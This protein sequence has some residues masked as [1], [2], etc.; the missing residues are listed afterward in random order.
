MRKRKKETIDEI[1]RR[2][3]KVR[4]PLPAAYQKIY[5]Q[6]YT[7]NRNAVTKASKATAFMERW[8]HK[9]VAKTLRYVEKG[10]TLEI[11]AGTLNQ[12]NF[13]T[14]T[15]EYDIVE[16]YSILFESSPY[17]KFVD[18]V[19][20]DISL[21]PLEKKYDRIISILSFEHILNLPNVIK[22]CG[23]LLKD[24]GFMSVSIP[25]E[26]RF[27]W[28]F[29]YRNTSGREFQRRFGLDYSVIMHY[30][31]VNTADE[32]EALIK[33]YF[34]KVTISLFGIGRDWSFYRNYFCMKP[35][36]TKYGNKKEN[37]FMNEMN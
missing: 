12:F 5:A 30:E 17:L 9:Q 33:Y 27:L 29:A 11:G 23:R 16:P 21:I 8:C 31:H 25:N 35:D 10:S 24:D 14:K 4:E 22:D 26:G 34:Q 3:P 28:E 1:L 18:E 20:D 15:G 7:E 13:E 19:Y 32:I 37:T 6:H 2:F 36:I